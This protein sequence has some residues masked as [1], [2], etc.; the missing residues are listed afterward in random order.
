MTALS[1]V[2]V[3]GC[4]FGLWMVGCVIYLVVSC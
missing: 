2:V 4:L 1:G 3:A